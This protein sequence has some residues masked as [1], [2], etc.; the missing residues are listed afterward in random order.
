MGVAS[1]IFGILA[2]IIGVFFGGL[3]GW[4]GAILALLGIILGA[5]GRK[6]PEKAGV[7]TGGLVCSVIGMVLCL[8]T[9]IACTACVGGSIALFH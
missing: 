7:A 6:N 8:I 4:A 1:L 2:I 9:Y 5:V 3:F